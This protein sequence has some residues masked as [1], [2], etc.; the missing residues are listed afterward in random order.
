MDGL[1]GIE[2]GPLCHD[3]LNNSQQISDDQMNM[4]LILASKDPISIDAISSLLAGQDPSLIRHLVTLHNDLEGC[5]DPRLIRIEGI[6]VGDEKRNFQI[7]DSGNRSKYTDFE[8][9]AFGV[10]SC[11][12]LDNRLHFNLTVDNQVNKVE[13]SIDGQYLNQIMLDNFTH[14]SFDLGSLKINKD[15][16][17]MIFAYDKYL[18]YSSQRIN[19]VTSVS[20]ND[21][22]ES[23]RIINQFVLYNNFPIPFNPSTTISYSIPIGGKVTLSIYDVLGR[24]VSTLVDEVKSSGTYDEKFNASSL[25]SGIYYYIL[26]TDAY[27]ETKKM[28]LLK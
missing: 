26:Q 23:K 3:F 8:S 5:S 11:Y 2:N 7:N 17:I 27:Q 19:T 20:I 14:F 24:E 21:D 13:V 22:P 10:D 15:T 18:N 6:K 12:T 28:I 1:Q 16:E 4:R 25:T 9:P